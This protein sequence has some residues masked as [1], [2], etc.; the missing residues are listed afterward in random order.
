M[1]GTYTYLICLGGPAQG[2]LPPSWILSLPPTPLGNCPFARGP[3]LREGHD[4]QARQLGL[5]A[6]QAKVCASEA[7]RRGTI[8]RRGD[9]P[10]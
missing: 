7:S 3:I 8:P 1:E 2:R 10:V 5:K 9:E 4:P 6:R